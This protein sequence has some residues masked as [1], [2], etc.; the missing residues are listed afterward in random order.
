MLIQD[1]GD[2]V[3][4][5]VCISDAWFVGEE[6]YLRAWAYCYDLST[7]LEN[8]ESEAVSWAAADSGQEFVLADDDSELSED[9]CDRDD[10]AGGGSGGATRDSP[11]SKRA[12]VKGPGSQ[13][14]STLIP[15][16]PFSSFSLEK[17]LGYGRNGCVFRACWKGNEVAVKQFD[18]EFQVSI[19]EP[20]KRSEP[21]RS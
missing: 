14:T 3:A 16:V 10:N 11:P 9:D 6:N 4:G 17:A 18:L 15:T 19:N 21:T 8:Y 1:E 20:K 5:N 13:L 7:R 12:K 2:N